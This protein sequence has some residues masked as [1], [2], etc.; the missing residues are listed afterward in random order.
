MY[1]VPSSLG[2]QSNNSYCLMTCDTYR[3]EVIKYPNFLTMLRGELH[4]DV[5]HKSVWLFPLCQGHQK[6]VNDTRHTTQLLGMCQPGIQFVNC[7][8]YIE[9]SWVL[10]EERWFS[11][12]KT[13]K[14]NFWQSETR[15]LELWNFAQWE[16]LSIV[17]GKVLWRMCIGGLGTK[18]KQ[19]INLALKWNH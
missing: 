12:S 13:T 6:P 7:K 14:P 4:C 11:V 18:I 2:M 1:L 8:A 17:P 3:L 16:I 5:S 15:Q 9:Q 10:T 19:Q